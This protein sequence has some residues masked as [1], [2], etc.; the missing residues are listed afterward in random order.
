METFVISGIRHMNAVDIRQETIYSVLRHPQHRPTAR[1]WALT[2]WLGLV[3]WAGTVAWI[4]QF[5]PNDVAR[6]LHALLPANWWF[7]GAILLTGGTAA[8]LWVRGRAAAGGA[9]AVVAAFLLGEIPFGLLSRLI[10][11]DFDIPIRGV[12]DLFGFMGSRLAWGVGLVGTMWLVT[13]LLPT[14]G[15]IPLALGLG[16]LTVAGRDTNTKRVPVAWSRILAGPYLVFC[17]VALV[18]LQFGVEFRPVRSGA[19]VQGLPLILGAA[20]VNA[21]VEEYIFRGFLQPAMIRLGGFGAG[22]WVQGGL[23]GLMHWGLGVGVLAALPVSLGIGFGSVIWG[24]AAL[25]TRGM[26]WVVLA[27]LLIDIAIMAAYFV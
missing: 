16:D 19:V 25:D 4:G 14:A 9:A 21:T 1:Q 2:I 27:H 8:L 13:R 23:F 24:K 18:L 20:V 11:N 26:L 17:A 5:R 6:G 22:L 12:G 10:P 7:W 3:A 15:R